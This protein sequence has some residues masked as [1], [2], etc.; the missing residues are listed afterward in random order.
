MTEQRIKEEMKRK[1]KEFTA[2]EIEHPGGKRTDLTLLPEPIHVYTDNER[3]IDFGAIFA[4][5]HGENPE[6]LITFESIR[7]RQSFSCE[8]VR[9][10]GAEMHVAW[11][12]REIWESDHGD[13]KPREKIPTS[14]VSFEYAD[15][16][17]EIL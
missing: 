15:L 9:V 7:G 12:G 10:G 6:V 1:A 5:A 11:K 3:N 17:A 2:Y 13:G 16:E 4:F 8:L 14:Y